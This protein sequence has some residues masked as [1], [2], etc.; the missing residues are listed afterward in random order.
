MSDMPDVI[1][2]FEGDQRC[3]T[4]LESIIDIIYERG[5]GISGPAILGVI[6]LAKDIIKEELLK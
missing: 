4:L 6:D 5:A 3:V 2:L 1:K